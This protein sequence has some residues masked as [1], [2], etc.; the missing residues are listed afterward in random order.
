MSAL[1]DKKGL[2]SFQ[3]MFNYLKK[4]SVQL[5]KL[6]KLL[7]PLLRIDVEWTCDSTHFAFDA[8]K[9]ELTK[10]AVLMYF[11]PKSEH[12]IQRDSSL[13]E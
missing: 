2:Q 3:G 11:N 13:K 12:V 8:I 9:E 1:K 5:L 4:Y 7:K 10:T 6:S